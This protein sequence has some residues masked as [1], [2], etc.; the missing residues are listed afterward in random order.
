MN[1]NCASQISE[2]AGIMEIPAYNASV[3]SNRS[4]S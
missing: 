3:Q 1:E 2:R 4:N